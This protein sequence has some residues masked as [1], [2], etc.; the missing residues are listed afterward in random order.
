VEGQVG[1]LFK[2]INMKTLSLSGVS[3]RRQQ[4]I[5]ICQAL[6]FGTIRG[7]SLQNGDPVLAMAS[8]WVVER[9][10][11]P[12]CPRPEIQLADFNLSKEWRRLFGRFDEIQTGVIERIEVRAGIPRR[13]IFES[14]M[15][16]IR[17]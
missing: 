4:L 3:L 2:G 15:S 5:R 6:N 11:S 10:D 17:P 14:R 13:V 1:S 9:L 12:E 8:L 16:E 7:A